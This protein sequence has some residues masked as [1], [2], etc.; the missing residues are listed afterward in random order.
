MNA[1]KS[2]FRASILALMLSKLWPLSAMSLCYHQTV[3]KV[4]INGNDRVKWNMYIDKETHLD[5]P[6]EFDL[7][8]NV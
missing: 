2:G 5:F 3:K 7:I 8:A 6:S 1:S 4:H